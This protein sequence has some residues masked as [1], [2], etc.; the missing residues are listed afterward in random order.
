LGA[1]YLTKLSGN[2]QFETYAGFGNGKIKN[3]HYSG[4]SVLN[5]THFFI[6]PTLIMGSK[7]KVLQ[8]GLVSK[9]AGVNFNVTDTL[10]ATGREPFSTKQLSSLYDQPFHVMWEPGLVVRVGWKK[11]Q[12]HS[13]YSFSADL[14]NPD[15]HKAN[16][17]FSMGVCLRLNTKS[18]K[19]K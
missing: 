7:N 3:L 17:N 12:L 5:L 8:V 13:G 9:F 15:L 16:G 1:G 11:L 2:M 18:K 4:R 10:F 6:Q 14:T 19:E